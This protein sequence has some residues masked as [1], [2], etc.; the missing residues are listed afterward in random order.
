MSYSLL[1]T[2]V[3]PTSPRLVNEEAPAIYRQVQVPQTGMNGSPSEPSEADQP[4]AENP[5]TTF[6]FP[7]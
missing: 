3:G 5:E 2:T 4:I 7:R 1:R 6:S